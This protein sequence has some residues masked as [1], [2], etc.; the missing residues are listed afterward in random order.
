VKNAEEKEEGGEKRSCG[1]TGTTCSIEIWFEF[2]FF[3]L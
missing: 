3:L 1:T 2:G